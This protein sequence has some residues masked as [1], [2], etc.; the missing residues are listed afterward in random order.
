MAITDDPELKLKLAD[1]TEKSVALISVAAMQVIREQAGEAAFDAARTTDVA[2]LAIICE[3]ETNR[4][5]DGLRTALAD[6]TAAHLLGLGDL[7]GIM[8][9]ESML[10]IGERAGNRWVAE[11]GYGKETIH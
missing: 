2:R 4:A 1:L 6:A 11:Q 5:E 10:T 8:F 7:A 3:E 9:A